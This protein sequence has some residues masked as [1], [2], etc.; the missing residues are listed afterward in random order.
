M[1]GGLASLA[2]P[3]EAL[4]RLTSSELAVPDLHELGERDAER[5]YDAQEVEEADVRLTALDR[6]DVVAVHGNALPQVLLAQVVARTQLAHGAAEGAE[7]VVVMG[8]AAA[9]KAY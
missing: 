7:G 8:S 5:G 1:S 2:V 4:E 3:A 6:A 9:H